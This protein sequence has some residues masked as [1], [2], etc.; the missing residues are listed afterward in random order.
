MAKI[1]RI[2]SGFRI[3]AILRR[4]DD[5]Q[6]LVRALK[7]ENV[8]VEKIKAMFPPD[9]PDQGATQFQVF[10][11]GVFTGTAAE[12]AALA[13]TNSF[14]WRKPYNCKRVTVWGCGGGGGG[15]GGFTRASGNAGGGGGGG[16]SSGIA[17]LDFKAQDVPDVLQVNVGMGGPGGAAGAQGGAGQAAQQTT[18][19]APNL[20][21]TL[22][23]IV[24]ASG[25]AG[26][27]AAGSGGAGGS[28]GSAPAVTLWTDMAIA[29]FLTAG[30]V[31]AAGGTTG[32]G[33]SPTAGV[34]ILMP[35][36]GGAGVTAGD[37]TSAGGSVP[38][39]LGL[40]ASAAGAAGG[41]G[42]GGDGGTGY[43][44]DPRNVGAAFTEMFGGGGGG[45]GGV[46]AGGNG[47]K[48]APGTGGGGGGAGTTGGS[49]GN[50]GTGLVIIEAW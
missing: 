7:L 31:G 14:T 46:A 48:G 41:A 47:G 13:R 21:A 45:S 10:M 25:N 9:L 24:G 16:A 39:S 42:V 40:P 34:N 38:S 19:V 44:Q 18:I 43:F 49:G 35:G 8:P 27:G 37:A 50:G 15:G 33:V 11:G 23:T 22:V 2:G 36:A 3:E 20:N 12:N 32:T 5:V 1:I 4:H 6:E 17:R 30:T 26:G 29:K 28:G